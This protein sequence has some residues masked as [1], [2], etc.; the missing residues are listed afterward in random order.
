MK[1]NIASGD[2]LEASYDTIIGFE[3]GDGTNYESQLDF[4]GTGVITNFSNSTDA[5]AI[6]SHTV[7]AGVVQFV[8]CRK[9]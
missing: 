7:T 8:R 2:T 4:Y 1:Y 9:L 3:T 6:T 5:G